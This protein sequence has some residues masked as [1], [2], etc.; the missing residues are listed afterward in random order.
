MAHDGILPENIPQW[1]RAPNLERGSCLCCFLLLPVM[2]ISRL[3]D[4]LELR[5]PHL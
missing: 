4:L 5:F 1:L 2:F 3:F